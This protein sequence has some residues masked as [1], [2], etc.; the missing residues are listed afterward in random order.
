M[1]LQ[2]LLMVDVV[3]EVEEVERVRSDSMEGRTEGFAEETGVEEV[4]LVPAP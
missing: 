4:E 3:E 1:V 2:A